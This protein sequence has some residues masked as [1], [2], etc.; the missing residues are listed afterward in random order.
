[1]AKKIREQTISLISYLEKVKDDDISDNQDV[2]RLFC[3]DNNAVNEL[4][5]TVLTDDYIPPLILGEIEFSE[6]LV[7]QY[8]VDGMQR[9]SALIKFRYANY[10]I[11]PSIEDS[12]IKYQRKKR[13][14]N[15]KACKDED[16]N[17][18]WDY[19]QFDIKGKT[20]EMLPYELKKK[21]DDYQVRIAIHQNC[22]MEQISKLVRRYNNHKSMGVSQKA[23]TYI[24]KFARKIRSISQSDFFRNCVNYSD[25]ERVKGTYERIVC[26]SVMSTS[27]LEQ[28]K[29]QPKQM[30]IFLNENASIEDFNLIEEYASRLENVCADKFT[31][32]FV[33]KDIC[34][35]FSVF[36]KFTKLGISD[37]KFAEYMMAIKNELHNKE[38]SGV[39]YDIMSKEK[40]TKDKRIISRKI[41][42]LYTLMIDYLDIDNFEPVETHKREPLLNFVR[43]NVF[44]DITDEDLEFYRIVLDDLTVEVDN[45]SKL[46]EQNN[47]KSLIALVAYSSV[48]DI[49]LEEWIADYFKRNNTYYKD[50]KENYLYMVNDLNH[51]LKQKGY[52]A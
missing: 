28:W 8:I 30:S 12:V 10:K 5:V 2:Q 39:S 1:M 23:F 9:S 18:I 17:V 14:E 33:L 7:Q 41:E 48:K 36:N 24:D 44:K 11:S 52:V 46:L 15:N 32:L 25:T 42:T 35:W 37:I 27:Y 49:D 31:N 50:Q 6:G 43:N 16:G 40:N 29:K 47:I 26:E 38:V 20:F 22:T 3:W 51:F 21:F 4:I 13:D 34:V 19:V 45:N